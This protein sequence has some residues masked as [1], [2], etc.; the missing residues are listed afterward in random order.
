MRQRN[1]MAR[2]LVHS[3]AAT[4]GGGLTYLRNLLTQLVERGRDHHWHVLLPYD[5]PIPLPQAPHVSIVRGRSGRNALRRVYMDQVWLRQLVHREQ[6]DLILATG[7]FGML[8]PPVPQILLARNALYFSD[9]YLAHLRQRAEIVELLNIGMRRRMAASSVR[10]SR[11]IVVPTAAFGEQIRM[12][13]PG[14]PADRFRVIPHGF[15]HSYVTPSEPPAITST[16]DSAAPPARILFVSHYNYYRN[17]EGMLHALAH[18]KR[19]APRRIELL[20][21]TR[22]GDGVRDH[23]YDTSHAARLMRQL[24]V[25]DRVTMLGTVPHARLSELY[26][27]ADVVVCPSLV[28]SFGH[29]MVEAMAH[30]RPLVVSDLPVH[31]EIC[32][33]AALYADVSDPR[34]LAVQC[35]R[36]IERAPLAQQLSENG[37]RR[38]ADFHWSTH[39][40][41]L[42]ETI[43][44][45]CPQERPRAPI[46][47]AS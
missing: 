47:A 21:T 34:M 29:P 1:L 2:V 36:I 3:L 17:F 18:L 19:T 40:D 5:L 37:C 20:L 43:A 11:L 23:R 46:N 7:N 15:S 25:E 33:D 24:G 14:I 42:M 26:R 4:A 27:S 8:M 30:G 16:G 45:V 32:R 28:E 22:L 10:A 35:R 12:K 38:A 6:F 9:D 44:E 31:R 13:M 39:F 41:G